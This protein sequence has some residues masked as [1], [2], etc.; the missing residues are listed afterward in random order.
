MLFCCSDTSSVMVSLVMYQLLLWLRIPF[1]FASHWKLVNGQLSTRL[2][3]RTKESNACASFWVVKLCCVLKDIVGTYSPATNQSIVWAVTSSDLC[4]K[5]WGGIGWALYWHNGACASI[6][7]QQQQQRHSLSDIDFGHMMHS[8]TESLTDWLTKIEFSS[9]AVKFS[10]NNCACAATHPA[11]CLN[12][13]NNCIRATVGLSSPWMYLDNACAASHMSR[14]PTCWNDCAC[15]AFQRS[16][17]PT[18]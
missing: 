1:L 11:S 5:L 16:R 6:L 13:C 17:C 18:N 7:Q 12:Y 15:V 2:G 10:K 14:C 8:L 9:P 4:Q 3:T